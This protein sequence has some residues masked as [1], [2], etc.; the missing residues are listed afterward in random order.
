M[1]NQNYGLIEDMIQTPELIRDFDLASVLDISNEVKRYK[2]IYFTGEG[3]SRLFP[4]GRTVF[5]SNFSGERTWR[6]EGAR[7]LEEVIKARGKDSFDTYFIILSNSGKTSEAVDLARKLNQIGHKGRASI[8]AHEGSTL[9]Q[10]AP[11]SITLK[12]GEERAVAATKSVVEQALVCHAIYSTVEDQPL[13]DLNLIADKF[14]E[15][16]TTPVPRTISDLLIIEG[17]VYFAGSSNG[18]IDEL[19]LKCA[20]ILRKKAIALPGTYCMHGIE[21]V[22]EPND[23]L[24]LCGSFVPDELKIDKFIRQAT[25]IRVI[26]ISENCTVFDDIKIPVLERS[27]KPYIE[28]AAGWALLLATGLAMGHD[29]DNPKRARKIGNED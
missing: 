16:I 7:A 4:A 28:L 27:I 29:L 11:K 2:K 1:E 26:S 14:S 8:T 23:T 5:E 21:E 20:E 24:V 25:K 22:L 18:C 3:S 15:Q 10:L 6:S 9:E 19:A 17:T 12:C 13:P